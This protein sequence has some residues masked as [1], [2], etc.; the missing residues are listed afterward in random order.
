M[1][2][3][4]DFVWFN[5]KNAI[6]HGVK[7]IRSNTSLTI[8]GD[9]KCILSFIPLHISDVSF[10]QQHPRSEFYLFIY[11]FIKNMKT[12]TIKQLGQYFTRYYSTT[13]N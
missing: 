7:H 10:Y 6:F 8:F 9:V 11:F 4:Q 1:R 5:W 3:K 12:L 13:I 2:L